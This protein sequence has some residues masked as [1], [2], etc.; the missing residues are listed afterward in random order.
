M[1]I[2]D[3]IIHVQENQL[4]EQVFVILLEVFGAEN[5]EIA[6]ELK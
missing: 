5:Q 4:S 1:S 2:L 3:M 6:P